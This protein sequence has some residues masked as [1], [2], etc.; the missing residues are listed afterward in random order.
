MQNV[1]S[2]SMVNLDGDRVT[3]DF[4]DG[5]DAGMKYRSCLYS[6]LLYTSTVE[7]VH[8]SEVKEGGKTDV[9]IEPTCSRT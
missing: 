6:C 1:A 2:R 7:S 4:V 9:K 3:A 5:Y 8:I